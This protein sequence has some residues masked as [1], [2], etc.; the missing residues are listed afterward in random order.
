MIAQWTAWLSHTRQ[1]HPTIQVCP[2]LLLCCFCTLN[3]RSQELATDV[4]R[5]EL[6]RR[7]AALLE[8]K[9]AEE[10]IQSLSMPMAQVLH[11]PAVPSQN[12]TQ[13]TGERVDPVT[14]SNQELREKFAREQA[15]KFRNDLPLRKP[16]KDEAESWTPRTAGRRG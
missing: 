12:I 5:I 7:N 10:R 4:A 1:H 3:P 6:T 13:I 15:S 11:S 2:R 16:E 14:V 8:A 9:V